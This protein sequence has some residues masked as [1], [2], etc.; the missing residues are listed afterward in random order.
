MGRPYSQDLRER[1][2]AA[3]DGGMRAYAAAPVFKVSVSYIYKALGR[4][5]TTGET[6]ARTGR[7][8]RKAKLAPHDEALRA[9]IAEHPDATL[10]EIKSWLASDHQVEV[11]VGCLW[12]RLRRLDL[13]LKKVR[14]RRRAGSRRCRSSAGGLAWPASRAERAKARLPRRDRSGDQHG[15]PIRPLSPGRAPPVERATGPL[16]NHDLHRRSQKRSADC[17]LRPR[18]SD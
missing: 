9:H 13:P 5:R 6:R 18:R 10:A 11:S 4:R 7:A 14:A 8:G 16:E 15:A 12:N 3:V 17:P 1:V 2:M